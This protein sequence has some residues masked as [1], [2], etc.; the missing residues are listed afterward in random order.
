M[1]FNIGFIEAMKEY[2]W[3][4]LIFHDVDLIPEDDRN[5]YRYLNNI[6]WVLKTSLDALQTHG[7]C[8]WQWTS[9]NMNCPTN[10]YLGGLLPWLHNNSGDFKTL[11]ISWLDPSWTVSRQLNG[12]SNMFWGWGGEDD[13]M[14]ARVQSKGDQF[15]ISNTDQTNQTI[16]NI[17]DKQERRYANRE[18]QCRDC[19]VQDDQTPAGETKQDALVLAQNKLK[20]VSLKVSN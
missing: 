4:C 12:F 3:T 18:V 1:L 13:D 10:W 5:I 8:R 15:N 14:A 17:S 7:T 9:S 6:L 16:S 11:H 19:E 20:E 2:N